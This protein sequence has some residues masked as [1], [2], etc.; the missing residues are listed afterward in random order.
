MEKAAVS[1]V[2]GQ[3]TSDSV[4]Q[5]VTWLPPQTEADDGVERVVS[6]SAADVSNIFRSF[7]LILGTYPS[8]RLAYS[9]YVSRNCFVLIL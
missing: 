9:Q 1:I 2:P 5:Q 8:R 7:Y 3:S 4:A 6:M